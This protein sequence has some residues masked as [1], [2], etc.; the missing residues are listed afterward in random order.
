MIIDVDADHVACYGISRSMTGVLILVNTAPWYCKRY[1]RVETS[2]YSSG[3]VA[4]RVA[5]EM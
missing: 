3:L 5:T 4:A 1:N 2:T